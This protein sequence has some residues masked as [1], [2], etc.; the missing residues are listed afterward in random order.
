MN[1]NIVPEKVLSKFGFCPSATVEKFGVGL[2]HLTYLVRDG[3][4]KYILQRMSPIFTPGILPDMCAVSEYLSEN[5]SETQKLIPTLDG[6]LF[7]EHDDYNWRLLTFIP[8]RVFQKAKDEEMAY[9]AGRILGAFHRQ[10]LFFNYSFAKGREGKTPRKRYQKFLRVTAGQ[11]SPQIEYL[12]GEISRLPDYFLPRR[13]SR[14][15]VVH[16]DP[17]ISNI[18]WTPK[19]K[20]LAIALIDTDETTSKGNTILELGDAFRSWCGGVEH[21]SHNA[22]DMKKFE[23]AKTGYQDGSLGM[24]RENEE[25]LLIQAVKIK[26]LELASRFLVDYFE[27]CYFGWNKKL[28]SSRKEHNLARAKGQVALYKSIP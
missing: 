24:L 28:F 14:L 20:R 4:K 12:K 18:I 1:E 26:C 27:D 5:G 19:G 10:L 15:R 7:V 21:D 6:K 17:K 23:A 16:G 13:A 3:R 22:F 8:G 11:H 25:A 9:E 2:I